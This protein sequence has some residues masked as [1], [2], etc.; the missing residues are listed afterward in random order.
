[1][2]MTSVT[3]TLVCVAALLFVRAG[4]AA[5][6]APATPAHYTRND[7]I[8]LARALAEGRTTVDLLIATAPGTTD[9]V[10]TV[11][12]GIGARI[13]MRVPDVGYIRARTPLARADEVPAIADIAVVNVDAR[14][15][16]DVELNGVKAPAVQPAAAASDSSSFWPVPGPKTPQANPFTGVRDVGA[17]A[18]KAR[19]PTYDGRGVRIAFLEREDPTSPFLQHARALDGTPIPKF[20]AMVDA[21]RPSDLGTIPTEADRAYFGWTNM[22]TQVVATNRRFTVD[23]VHY[24]APRDGAFRFGTF[25]LR[26]DVT[27]VNLLH[28]KGTRFAGAQTFRV[29]WDEPHG[30]VWMDTNQD[31]SFADE[32]AM[33]DF[34]VHHDVGSLALKMTTWGLWGEKYEPVETPATKYVFTIETDPADHFV[35]I[36]MPFHSIHGTGVAST[37]VGQGYF[38]GAFDGVAPGAQMVSLVDNL[39][40]YSGGLEGLLGASSYPNV[41][42]ISLSWGAC[43]FAQDGHSVMDTVISRMVDVR[44]I[45]P[46][47]SASNDGPTMSTL[48]S[49]ST[50]D[51]AV[52]V[53]A[54]TSRDIFAGIDGAA[55]TRPDYLAYYSSRGPRR[56]GGFKP[57]LVAP[58]E[59]LGA[60]PMVAP[61]VRLHGILLP[62]GYGVTNGTSTAA[63]MAAGSAALLIS[64][65]KQAGIPHDPLRIKRAMV[66][67]ARQ[68]ADYTAA[69][70][71]GGL[72]DVNA[73]WIALKAMATADPVTITTQ[74]PV[75]DATSNQLA[76]A[77]S[78]RRHLRT[79]RLARGAKRHAHDHVYAHDRSGR[80][81]DVC[82]ALDP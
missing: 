18:F 32:R 59:L 42:L 29:L 50:A 60:K 49:P 75:A 55:V 61:R 62:I 44:G 9:A 47:I 57:D 78:R 4:G 58:T 73:A 48:C 26:D 66:S 33:R 36:H 30:I 25:R 34:S 41:D 70:Q 76:V 7:R 40:P 15:Q 52:S 82:R 12:R 27:F 17:A 80:R 37:A 74:A 72:V 35:A 28:P 43:L 39:T 16:S 31:G 24:R 38:G 5:Q 51:S 13:M 71:G 65:A 22:K 67:G 1:M 81:H 21:L 6:T 79:R 56:D 77:H 3:R 23:G 63:P 53:G 20:V 46:F 11:L 54:Y 64:A 14:S 8:L 68:L 19:H 10:A 2:S 69:E 45:L